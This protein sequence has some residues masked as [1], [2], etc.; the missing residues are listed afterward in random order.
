MPLA[1]VGGGT[2][3]FRV[4]GRL[5]LQLFTVGFCRLDRREDLQRV[6]DVDERGAAGG[7]T[8]ASSLSDD[9][10]RAARQLAK[11]LSAH[12]GTL[13]QGA[14]LLRSGSSRASLAHE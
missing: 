1:A 5:S 8:R 10:E 6:G 12:T 13:A 14:Q 11:P 4:G 3:I 7:R 9:A 2:R